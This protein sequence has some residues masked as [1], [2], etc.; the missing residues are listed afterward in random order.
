MKRRCRWPRYNDHQSAQSGV[1]AAKVVG[2]GERSMR[3]GA[4][5]SPRTRAAAKATVLT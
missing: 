3:R 4:L 2:N 5:A 1:A